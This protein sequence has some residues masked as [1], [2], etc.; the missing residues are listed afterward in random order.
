[1]YVRK[2]V[3]FLIYIAGVVFFSWNYYKLKEALDTSSF[4]M[5]AVF[6]L[7]GVSRFATFASQK[8]DARKS[9]DGGS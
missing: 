5:F 9:R 3:E 7:F 8:I 2:T 6:F 4:V 1:M